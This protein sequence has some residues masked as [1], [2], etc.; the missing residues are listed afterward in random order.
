MKFTLSWLKEHLDTNASVDEISETLTKIGL[1]VE[2]VINP[3]AAL[4]GFVTAEITTCEMHPD[5]DHL[6]LLTVNDGSKNYQVVCGAPNAKLGLKGIFAP[7][8]VI[9]P[10]YGEEL[11]VGKIR[12]VES[13][14]MMCSEKEL[15][16]GDDHTGIIELPS[17]TKIGLP[18]DDAL[19]TTQTYRTIQPEKSLQKAQTADRIITSLDNDDDMLHRSRIVGGAGVGYASCFAPQ[20]IGL[21]MLMDD[22]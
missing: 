19:A 2:E 13:F 20:Y 9:I 18:A 12:G 8:G 5:S 22:D 3:A 6:H 17:D 1:E 10:C 7:V 15:C 11:K 14:G 16:V 4:K 21:A